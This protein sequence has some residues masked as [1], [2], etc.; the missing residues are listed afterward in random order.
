MNYII[1]M[2]KSPN[3]PS[4]LSS[5]SIGVSFKSKSVVSSSNHTPVIKSSLNIQDLYALCGRLK[6]WYVLD[7]R[8]DSEPDF[9]GYCGSWV[10]KPAGGS[11][12]STGLSSVRNRCHLLAF[13]VW[14]VSEETELRWDD[15][16]EVVMTGAGAVRLAYAVYVAGIL[17]WVCLWKQIVFI[18]CLLDWVFV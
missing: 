13:L 2:S 9:A 16:F 18:G 10:K 5:H 1:D 15:W 12:V 4:H 17:I 8:G 3:T 7:G 6:W 14:E 11:G